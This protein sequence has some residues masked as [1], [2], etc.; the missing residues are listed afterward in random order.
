MTMTNTVLN[1]YQKISWVKSKN[2]VPP[3]AININMRILKMFKIKSVVN[4]KIII[5]ALCLKSIFGVE[6]LS[7]KRK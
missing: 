5:D 6:R 1:P 2:E 7:T 3:L 4:E